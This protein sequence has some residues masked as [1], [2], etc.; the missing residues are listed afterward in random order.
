MQNILIVEN[1]LKRQR[2]LKEIIQKRFPGWG[3]VCATD[4]RGGS[5][6]I[7]DSIRKK[8]RFSLFILEIQLNE[9]S[10]TMGGFTLAGEIRAQREY[11][12][13]PI[14]FLASVPDFIQ[15]AISNYHCYNYI[16][17]PYSPADIVEKIQQMRETGALPDDTI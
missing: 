1:D 12:M 7:V 11:Q 5:S 14:M 6:L 9:D 13:T 16:R 8:T 17:E 10:D 4:C 3:I 15:E 2:T